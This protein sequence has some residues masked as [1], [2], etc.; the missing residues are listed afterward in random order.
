MAQNIGVGKV[1]SGHHT[2]KMRTNGKWHDI[3]KTTHLRERREEGGGGLK[4][5][6]TKWEKIDPKPTEHRH[7]S[8]IHMLAS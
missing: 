1:N 2:L 8:Y 3:P 4:E 7:L 6:I 5:F